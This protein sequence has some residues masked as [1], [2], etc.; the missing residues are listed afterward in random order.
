MQFTYADNLIPK[1]YPIITRGRKSLGKPTAS[2]K[3]TLPRVITYDP[4]PTC[5]SFSKRR[6]ISLCKLDIGTINLQLVFF[7][8]SFSL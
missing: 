4:Q 6:P 2:P 7:S 1:T 8:V 3:F 5:M